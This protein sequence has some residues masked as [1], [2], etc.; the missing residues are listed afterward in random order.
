MPTWQYLYISINGYKVDAILKYELNMDVKQKAHRST[1]A[2]CGQNN[3]LKKCAADSICIGPLIE[4]STGILSIRIVFGSQR[5]IILPYQC[6]VALEKALITT[7]GLH[8]EWYIHRFPLGRYLLYRYHPNLSYS[9]DLLL[10]IPFLPSGWKISSMISSSP[11]ETGFEKSF[12]P[13]LHSD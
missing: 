12:T 1:P 4:T 6:N 11:C 7:L 3:A 8:S 2:P 9:I 5:G 13:H 10:Y